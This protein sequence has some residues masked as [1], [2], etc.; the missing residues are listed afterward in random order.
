MT[1][2]PEEISVAALPRVRR[3][4]VDPKAVAELLG[5]AAWEVMGTQGMNAK[6]TET[7]E[8]LTARVKELE[9]QVAELESYA[10]RHRAPDDVARSLLDSARRVALE[11]RQISRREA[12]LLLKKARTR[13]AEIEAEARNREKVVGADLAALLERRAQLVAELRS[14]LQAVVALGDGTSSE[15]AEPKAPETPARRQLI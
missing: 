8:R 5:R 14:A 6:L 12:E 1:L 3:D 10:A 2:S 4:G 15:T 7:V 13:A 9:A 11:Q